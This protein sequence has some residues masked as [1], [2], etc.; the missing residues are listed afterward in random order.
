ME[1]MEPSLIAE[2]RDVWI[3][4]SDLFLDTDVRLSYPYVARVLAASPYSMDQLE[5]IFQNE[6]APA[7]ESNLFDIA[8][9]WA[10]FPEAWLIDTITARP[11][12]HYQMKTTMEH[13]RAVALLAGFLRALPPET[14]EE[15]TRMWQRMSP[16]FLNRAPARPEGLVSLSVYLYE[17]LPTYGASVE[18][19]R[20]HNPKI[21]PTPSEI[22]AQALN[23]CLTL[24]E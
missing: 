7:V 19:Y 6:V 15:R 2:R 17:M 22:E 13:F 14:R 11:P 24:I 5:S 12:G 4:V 20:K 23:W 3:A 9:E 16:L 8:G 10:G 18:A 21:Y 1:Q